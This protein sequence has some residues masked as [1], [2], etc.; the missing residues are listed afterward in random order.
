[1]GQPADGGDRIRQELQNKASCDRIERLG[2]PEGRDIG[3]MKARIG[4]PRG[5]RSLSCRSMEA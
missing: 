1:L 3:T 4:K 2:I 5:R